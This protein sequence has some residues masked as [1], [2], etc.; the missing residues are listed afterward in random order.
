MVTI[1]CPWCEQDEPLELSAPDEPEATFTC[2]D[3]GTSVHFVDE[4]VLALELA[5]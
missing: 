2:L 5:A 4:P 3:C 1:N